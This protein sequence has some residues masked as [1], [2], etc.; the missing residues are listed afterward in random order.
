VDFAVGVAGRIA[1]KWGRDRWPAGARVQLV[2][3]GTGGQ[4]FG[5]FCVKG[6][7]LIHVGSCNDHVGK[8]MSG[9]RIVVRQPENFGGRSWQTTIVGNTVA[10]GAT[11]GKI[12]VQGRAGQRLGVRNSGAVIVCEGAG[13][14]ACEYMTSGTAVFLGPV[15]DHI[16]AG[17]T[18]GTAYLYDPDGLQDFRFMIDE[19]SVAI[20]VP[21]EE[22]LYDV[23]APLLDEFVEAT[24][25]ERAAEAR[26]NLYQFTKITPLAAVYEDMKRKLAVDLGQTI[27]G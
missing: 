25:S 6:M 17:M 21:G 23:L 11:G 12:F 18:D 4:S 8:G 15:G 22:E 9:G 20:S 5:A 7:D 14:Y 10:F 24:G 27:A 1:R 3:E 16:G 26:Q 13:Q 19:R 2:T